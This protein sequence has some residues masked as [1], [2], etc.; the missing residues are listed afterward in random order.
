MVW[1]PLAFHPASMNE[2]IFIHFSVPV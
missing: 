2:A 1:K